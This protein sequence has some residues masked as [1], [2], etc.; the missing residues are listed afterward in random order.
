MIS[1]ESN[2]P[3]GETT[4][5]LMATIEPYFTTEPQELAFGGVRLEDV[6][7]GIEKRCVIERRSPGAFALSIPGSIP[8]GVTC[9]LVPVSPTADGHQAERWQLVVRIGAAASEGL[10][11]FAIVLI[12]DQEICGAPPEPDGRPRCYGG[13]I[14]VSAS[15]QG[16]VSCNPRYISFGIISSGKSVAR[17]IRIECLDPAFN[18]RLRN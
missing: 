10:I 15:V 8:R 6:L 5:Q 11:R 14:P 17:A 7:G 9:D 3:A 2:D 18:L 13:V 4:L 16:L 1:I 12:S